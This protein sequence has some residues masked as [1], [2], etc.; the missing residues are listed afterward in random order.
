M[1]AVIYKYGIN[2]EIRS[3]SRSNDPKCIIYTGSLLCINSC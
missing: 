3:N 1:S 2:G